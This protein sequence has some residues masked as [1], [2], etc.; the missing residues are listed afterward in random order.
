MAKTK[1]T[2]KVSDIIRDVLTER[3]Y[4]RDSDELLYYYVCMKFN[5][6]IKNV[7][8]ENLFKN[9]TYYG[10][11]TY[12]TVRR[13]RAKLQ[14]EYENLRGLNTKEDKRKRSRKRFLVWSS[15]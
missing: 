10:I 9:R 6:N 15:I 14:R 8:F 1:S 4:T 5:P 2:V 11:P 7:T 3:K 13:G 12:E